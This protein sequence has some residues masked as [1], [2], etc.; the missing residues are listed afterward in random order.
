MQTSIKFDRLKGLTT[1]Q[2]MRALAGAASFEFAKPSMMLDMGKSAVAAR[3]LRLLGQDERKAPDADRIKSWLKVHGA[4]YGLKYA[5]PDAND[6]L[7]DVANEMEE[8]FHTNMQE[9]DTAFTLLFDLVD[10]RGSTHDHFDIIDTNAGITFT[11][12]QPGAKIEVRKA[13]SE[14][15]TTVNYLSFSDGLGILDEWLQFNMFWNVDEA[16]AEFRAQWWD[17]MASYHYGLLTALSSSIDESFSTDDPTTFNNAA[18]TIL[19]AVRSKGYAAGQNAG[20]YIVCALEKVGR[21]MAM[22]SATQGSQM[23]SFGTVAQPIAYSVRGVIGTTHVTADDTGYYLVLPGRKMKRGVWKDL[24]VESGRNIYIKAE[25]MT[26][27]GQ[28][29]AAIGDSD[30]V[31]RVKYS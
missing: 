5:T 6:I 2:Q 9:M 3:E 4:K 23:V 14:S 7:T 18:G 8:F 29:N 11:Q 22:L 26:G 31:R 20:F 15:K 30:Q 24:Q 21:V 17:K 28:Y 1:E 13:I 27:D 12:R 16:L 10:L 19:R 25:D